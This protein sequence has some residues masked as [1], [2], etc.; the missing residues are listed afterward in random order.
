MTDDIAIGRLGD[1]HGIRGWLHLFS[2][3]N[4]PENIF[5]YKNWRIGN[6]FIDAESHR[7]HGDHF[8]VKLKGCDD[9][10]Q[11]LLLKHQD[12]LIDRQ[13]LPSLPEGEYYWHDLIGLSVID[14]HGKTLGIVDHL[15]S[16]GSNDVVVIK[17][18]RHN[19]SPTPT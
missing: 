15:F 16:T 2:Y 13:Q 5:Q 11:A 9:R 4:P 19:F 1:A 6:R 10:D 8:A 7:A 17:E 18:T 14:A 3:A 12:I